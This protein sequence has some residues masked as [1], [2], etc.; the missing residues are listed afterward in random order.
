MDC[1]TTVSPQSLRSI[2][3]YESRLLIL[4][5]G[6]CFETKRHHVLEIKRSVGSLDV[7]QEMILHTQSYSFIEKDNLVASSKCVSIISDAFCIFGF[8]NLVESCYIIVVTKASVVGSIHGHDI[9]T[10]TET[11]LIPVT[12]KVR[13][14]MEESRYKSILQNFN[15]ASQEFYFS[16]SYDLAKS[17]Q[18]NCTHKN[19][20]EKNIN[21]DKFIW[22][23][24]TLKVFLAYHTGYNQDA[25]DET[26]ERGELEKNPSMD[27]WI[28]PV[29]HG[30]FKQ[31]I[32]R[33]SSHHTLKYTLLARRSRI[34]A[35]TRY[36]RRGID[37]DGYTANEVET[38]QI[39]TEEEVSDCSYRSSSLIQI[40]GSIPLYWY[41]T[42]LFVPSPDIKLNVSDYGYNAAVKH[43]HMLKC[44]YG[45]NI[46]VLNL[47][48]LQ[49]S[50]REMTVGGAYKE[51]VTALNSYYDTKSG[52]ANQA[53][54]ESISHCISSGENKKGGSDRSAPNT[55]NDGK[56]TKQAE[57]TYM[58]KNENN[59]QYVAYDFHGSLHSN[60]FND[61]GTICAAIAP[62]S[63]FFVQAP[64]VRRNHNAKDGEESS[65]KGLEGTDHRKI[66]IMF[67][68][69]KCR[70]IEESGDNETDKDRD[71]GKEKVKEKNIKL[72]DGD[73]TYSSW[74][75]SSS[76]DEPGSGDSD[77][78]LRSLFIQHPLG[79]KLSKLGNIDVD[80]NDETPLGNLS[81]NMF[82]VSR[83]VPELEETSENKE[84][85]RGVCGGVLQMGVLRTNC[86]D[87]LDR[88]NVAQFC[89]A[90]HCLHSQIKALGQ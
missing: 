21:I 14:T 31:R 27:R 24:H 66:G 75:L 34:F 78:V 25:F 88:T 57:D 48:R 74:P 35:G 28:V 6:Q 23:Y 63:G 18:V 65:P 29:I 13:N 82:D 86:V 64:E 30:F 8:I 79:K 67:D 22:N 10:I 3:I 7:K 77:T 32:I 72:K 16:Y 20:S 33:S 5:I 84:L 39:V 76:Q 45:D 12:Y 69:R 53:T 43:F 83:N 49:N 59:I 52:D 85:G 73:Y 80:Q 37:L 87:C 2:S 40:R 70:T 42:N 68:G 89:Y 60:L 17:M 81:G 19:H 62:A 1:P 50:S 46:T 61:L 58:E 9:Y 51:L 56:S 71:V 54:H 41:H 90:R 36:L 11:N 4:I 55:S 26:G 38:E 15:L 44:V 47:V